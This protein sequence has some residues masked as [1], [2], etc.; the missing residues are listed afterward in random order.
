MAITISKNPEETLT[1]G[2][3]WGR[4]A[5]PGWVIALTGDLGAGKTQMVKGIARGLGV[6]DHVH[7]PTYT[8]VNEYQGGRLPLFHLDLYRLDTREQVVGAGLEEYFG[9]QNGVVVVEWAERWFRESPGSGVQL[10]AW[11]A[12]LR[13]VKIETVSETERLISYE[14]SGA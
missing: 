8:L 11:P 10:T 14:D 1:L 13:R 7:S 9:T 2:S 12:Q 5:R 3:Q 6:I 4:E